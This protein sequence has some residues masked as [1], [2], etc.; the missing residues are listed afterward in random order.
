MDNTRR[1]CILFT[2]AL[3]ASWALGSM[4][5]AHAGGKL[6]VVV[7]KDNPVGNLTADEIKAYFLKKK[8]AWPSG[9]KARPVDQNPGAERTGFDAK[10]L[11]MSAEEL[12][13]YW[14][15]LK[16][17]SAESAPKVVGDSAAVIQFV[18][19]NKGAFGYADAGAAAA[20]ADK[21]KVVLTVSY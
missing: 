21:V 1:R 5:L 15:E 19:A 7:N 3:G 4:H 10:V 20:A 16:Y 6:A 17:A 8:G 9:D 13:R 11:G 2:A 18:G 14:I 12:E